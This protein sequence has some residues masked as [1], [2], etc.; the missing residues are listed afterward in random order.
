MKLKV[1]VVAEWWLDFEVD[2]DEYDYE[3]GVSEAA[4]DR[5]IQ[6]S[7]SFNEAQWDVDISE[8]TP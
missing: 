8:V 1:K 7:E 6:D 5:V 3:D 4:I 2:D